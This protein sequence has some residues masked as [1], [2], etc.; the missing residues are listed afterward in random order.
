MPFKQ[1]YTPKQVLDVI[2]RFS[3]CVTAAKIA[4]HIGCDP[5]T[6]NKLLDQLEESGF[7][8]CSSNRGTAERPSILWKRTSKAI[9]DVKVVK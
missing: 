8:K 7:V 6:V 1:K 5:R 3:D 4:E 9:M 2:K